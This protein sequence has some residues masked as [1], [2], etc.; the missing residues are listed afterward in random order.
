MICA[1]ISENSIDAVFKRISLVPE[2]YDL[3]EI[4]VSE[5]EGID[6]SS[7][8]RLMRAS[9][10]PILLKIEDV[11]NKDVINWA[12][13]K[14]VVYID[15]DLSA[16]EKVFKYVTENKKN[17]KLII[18]YH[19]FEKTPDFEN[20]SQ[21]KKEILQNGADIGKIVFTALETK[22]NLVPLRLLCSSADLPLI[23]FCM[24]KT[25][26]MSRIYAEN[27]GSLVNFVP[28]DAGWQTADGQIVYERWA[29]I[30][31]LF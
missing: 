23:S 31:S 22:D 24:G 25:G 15:I 1:S 27:F 28:P 20:A 11:A 3:V 4:W 6:K 10:K 7:F 8:E 30:K 12:L 29:K 26:Q 9:E 5:I 19:D 21:I 2:F 17:T 14:E 18:S 16:G 13:Q